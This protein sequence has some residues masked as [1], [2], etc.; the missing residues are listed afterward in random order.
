MI[1]K[2][3]HLLGRKHPTAVWPHHAL[4][5]HTCGQLP[6]LALPR[7][8]QR[9]DDSP[10]AFTEDFREAEK[11]KVAARG[12]SHT[13]RTSRAVLPA[14]PA[15]GGRSGAEM[16]GTVVCA[17]RPPQLCSVLGS[18]VPRHCR[19]R[20]GKA[21]ARQRGGQAACQPTWRGFLLR[22]AVTGASL[23][24]TESQA[25]T[26][27]L[28]EAI[29]SPSRF[30]HGSRTSLARVPEEQPSSSH[31]A[32]TGYFPLQDQSG[33][34]ASHSHPNDITKIRTCLLWY[35]CMVPTA[36]RLCALTP[37]FFPPS[38]TLSSPAY[39]VKRDYIP[40]NQK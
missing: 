1:R 17:R 20:R 21:A 18:T 27:T 32:I 24:S 3:R 25:A 35:V 9:R 22:P 40:S 15:V 28:H 39:S 23:S 13:A 7:E 11:R 31:Q 16:R 8:G 37:Q 14:C 19:Q 30:F 34:G 29:S 38:F 5:V 36:G 6:F 26:Q 2:S 4:W 10:F 12:P 33:F